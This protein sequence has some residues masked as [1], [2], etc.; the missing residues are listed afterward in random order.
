VSNSKKTAKRSSSALDT[1][2]KQIS[3]PWAASTNTSEKEVET[4]HEAEV[5]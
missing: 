4:E 3:T 2:A 5:G 1:Y